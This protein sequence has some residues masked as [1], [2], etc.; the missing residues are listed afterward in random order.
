MLVGKNERIL[1]LPI[2]R[3]HPVEFNN[4]FQPLKKIVMV[5]Q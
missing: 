1:S 2:N 4:K 3:L 5:V